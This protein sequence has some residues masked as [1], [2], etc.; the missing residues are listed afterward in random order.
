M[1]TTCLIFAALLQVGCVWP[2]RVVVR[3]GAFG[4]IVDEQTGRVIAGADVRLDSSD[5]RPE[6]C[7][8]D[9]AGNFSF[10]QRRQLVLMWIFPRGDLAALSS[11]LTIEHS[12]YNVRAIQFT[13][14]TYDAGS[15]RLQRR[16]Q[17]TTCQ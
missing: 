9:Y 1:R 12:D 5:D 2:E 7:L 10:A 16:S 13:G 14:D 11:A 6:T 17:V 15:I 4:R 8:T 3:P